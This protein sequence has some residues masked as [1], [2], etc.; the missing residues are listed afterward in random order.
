MSNISS[1]NYVETNYTYQHIQGCLLLGFNKVASDLKL[2]HAE[3]RI[4]ATLIG[5]YNKTHGKAYPTTRQLVK[6]C[7]M[8]NTTLLKGLNKLNELGLIIT[9]KDSQFRRQQYHINKQ[10]FIN[11]SSA[12]NTKAINA[13]P[14]S[15]THDIKLIDNKTNKKIISSKIND[16]KF[17]TSNLSE[18]REILNK[19]D[20]WGYVGV[21]KI[22][23]QKGLKKIQ[24][25]IKLVEN[26]NPSNKGAYLRA[27]INTSGVINHP[28][29]K[30]S[31]STSEHDHIKQ[32][33]KH[34][35]WRHVPSGKVLQVKPD[36]GTHLLIRYHSNENMVEFLESGLIDRLDR[37]GTILNKNIIL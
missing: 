23:K 7:C 9:I 19:L 32:M 36:V 13:T 5:Y 22:I 29:I 18:Y 34:K 11:L 6:D 33:L 25:L 17:K 30:T 16:D 21:K 15:N 4:M 24:D 35:Y 31:L 8:S 3:Y 10:R 26:L 14:C 2:N 12:T 37:F 28:E 27:L 20:S 1:L